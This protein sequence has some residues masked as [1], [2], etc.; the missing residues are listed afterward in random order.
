LVG[1]V[2]VDGL[3]NRRK[4]KMGCV[5][6][7]MRERWMIDLFEV[8]ILGYFLATYIVCVNGNVISFE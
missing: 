6:F 7:D 8:V 1:F 4:W 5:D 3:T 2:V